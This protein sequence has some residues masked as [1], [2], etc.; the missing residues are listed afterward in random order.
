MLLN[1]PE[2]PIVVLGESM[3]DIF[4][5]GDVERISP[6]APVPVLRHRRDK[7]VAG[8]AGNV[9]CNVAK[10]GG[11]P[12]LITLVGD[13]SEGASLMA[14]LGAEG[15]TTEA[16]GTRG[17]MTTSKT[18][19]MSGSHHLMRIDREDSSP[20]SSTLEDEVLARIKAVLPRARALGISDYGKGML[21]DRVLVGAIAMARAR[22]VPVIVDPKRRDFSL[23]AGADVIKPNRAELAAASGLNCHTDEEVARAAEAVI[24]QTGA[25]LLV[26]RAEKGMSYFS[27]GAVPIHM[28]TQ[29]K[30][31][32]DVSGAG[33][34]VM[35]TF[36]YGLVGSLPIEQ[37]MRLANLAAGIVV[38]KP[39]TA[40][41]TLDELRAEAAL[42][43]ESAAFRKGGLASVG[44]ARAIREHWRRQGLT[45]GFTNGC[46]DL[47]HPGHVA[48]LR[49][50]ARLC[51]R[52]VVGLN[53]DQSVTRLKGPTRPVQ[54]AVAR[55]QVL[56]AIDCV[57]L[58]VIFE[59][60]TPYNLIGALMPD[61]LIKGADY[62]E[63]QIVGAD[64]VRS[65]GGRVER[66]KLV[67]GQSTSELIR[68]ANV[69]PALL[70]ERRRGLAS[71]RLEAH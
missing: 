55:A 71:P 50:A 34:A 48:I 40:T 30:L 22:G 46:F 49:G 3:L 26:T 2:A 5:T 36:A 14:L 31:V 27:S 24:R 45:V 19:L 41:I 59:D 23:Y 66:I 35:A 6:E 17:R 67:D 1:H 47:L 16:V 70:E 60:D 39:G 58:V 63:D 57:D 4:V 28:P 11:A 69:A 52:L 42:H 65:A 25:A 10:L 64:V 62:A 21:T 56:G 15:V 12:I 38:S 32:F 20:I 37:T 7:L 33:D 51:D 9:A 54:R 43:E 13:D 68:R 44:E 8:G 61:V 53:A 29:A 18:R